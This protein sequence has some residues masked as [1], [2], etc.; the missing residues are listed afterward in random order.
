VDDHADAV[1]YVL[2]HGRPGE[3]Y[4]VPGSG[5]RPNRD[6]VAAL[7]ARLDKPWSLVRSVADRPGHDRRY[8]MDG[9]RLAGLGW[10]RGMGFEEGIAA[11]VD[12]YRAHEAWWQTAR[13]GDWADYYARQYGERL[14]GSRPA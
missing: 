2:D 3:A 1:G 14:A 7:L 4:N 12:W 13:S 11:T 5:E 10:Q 6:V 8:A 9:T